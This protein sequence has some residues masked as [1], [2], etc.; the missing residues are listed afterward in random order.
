[1]IWLIFLNISPVLIDEKKS[2]HKLDIM[3]EANK[4][5]SSISIFFGTETSKIND[6]KN[7]KDHFNGIKDNSN[8]HEYL[9]SFNMIFLNYF[10]GFYEVFFLIHEWCL[11]LLTFFKFLFDILRIIYALSFRVLI[12]ITVSF[13]RLFLFFLHIS[14]ASSSTFLLR[15]IWRWVDIWFSMFLFMFLWYFNACI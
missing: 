13:F 10:H 7:C 3:N 8:L 5:V 12:F 6:T 4:L 15:N 9:T 14:L 11:L 1:M 2:L